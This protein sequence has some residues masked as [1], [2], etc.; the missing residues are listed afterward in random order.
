MKPAKE[1]QTELLR[2]ALVDLERLRLREHNAYRE[3]RVVLNA[4]HTLN[5]TQNTDQMF[6]ELFRI[7]QD[8]VGFDQ[9]FLLKMDDNG[10][11]YPHAATDDRLKHGSW[12]P[13]DLFRRVL[14]GETVALFDVSH[15][16]E[17]QAQ[18][19]GFHADTTSALLAPLRPGREEGILIGTHARRGAFSREQINLIKQF[20]P[21]VEQALVTAEVREARD[22]QQQLE[23]E[24]ELALRSSRMK[25]EFLSTMSH[26]LRTP[27]NAILGFSELLLS[28]ADGSLDEEQREF[29]EE[30]HIAGRH[31][32]KLINEVL[33]IGR[34]DAGKIEL[35]PTP[36][37]VAEILQEC[38]A[39]LDNQAAE[40]G[41]KILLQAARTR[42]E[43]D[44]FRL[45]Q[46][47]LNLISNAIKYNHNGGRIEIRVLSNEGAAVIEVEDSGIGM[48]PKQLAEAFEPF[49]RVAENKVDI[50]GTGMGLTI[51]RKLVRL[52]GGEIGA[53]ST[54][55]KGSLFRIIIPG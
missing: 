13:G 48:N 52:M 44:P 51:S 3:K 53:E 5:S 21:L 36:L 30:I 55:G 15:V 45:K 14:A 11:M 54:P 29:L 39:M 16:P 1:N 9:A 34:I 22:R 2:E 7:L 43:L 4:L 40:R 17:W 32:L 23:K 41:I 42:M 18:P 26:E 6:Q 27:M 38:V 33:D 46:V 10:L 24:K 8:V 31:L 47:C 12:Q 50:E 37:D 28:E 19:A 49:S 20:V 25:D 35:R